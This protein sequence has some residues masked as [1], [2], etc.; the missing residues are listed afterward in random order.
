MKIDIDWHDIEKTILVQRYNPGWT[1]DEFDE[2]NQITQN[3]IREQNN[4]VDVIA[5]FTA[6]TAIPFGHAMNHARSN[7]ATIPDNMRYMVIVSPNAFIRTL[8][9]MFNSLRRSDEK[10]VHCVSTME[11]ALQWIKQQ[12]PA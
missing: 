9:T 7:M 3:M 8:V 2:Y 10:F 4:R 12:E 1:W 11:Q 6:N 5:N